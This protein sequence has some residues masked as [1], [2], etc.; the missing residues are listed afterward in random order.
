MLSG[1][2]A[3]L[4][5]YPPRVVSVVTL[6]LP[7]PQARVINSLSKS[8]TVFALSFFFALSFS[9]MSPSDQSSGA[10]QGCVQ[11]DGDIFAYYSLLAREA[12]PIEALENEL[13]VRLGRSDVGHDK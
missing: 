7:L 1:R 5:Q 2:I 3:E 4:S 8:P 11:V 10:V 9:S 13:R 6:F 12:S